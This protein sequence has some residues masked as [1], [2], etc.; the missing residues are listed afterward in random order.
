M[1]NL[2]FSLNIKKGQIMKLFFALGLIGV[3]VAF[4]INILNQTGVIEKINSMEKIRN[5]V[6]SGG[7]YSAIIFI[8]LQIL[9]TTILQIPAFILTVVGALVFGTWQSF[10]LSY[11]A[12][13]IGSIIMFWIGRKAGRR[14]LNWIVGENNA[15]TWIEKLSRGKYLFFL[16]MIFPLFPD[17][18]LCVVAGFTNM[19]FSF[20]LWTNIIAR[21][22]GIACTV[23][24]GSGSIIPFKGWG[25]IIWGFIIAFIV[26]LFYTSVKKR[27]KIDE[28]LS[29]I[30]K[31]KKVSKPKKGK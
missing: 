31:K 10:F 15:D 27:D 13:M 29:N 1:K 5:I 6:E 8:I 9:Q 3:L 12:I 16:M 19:S 14:F 2:K 11:I 18:I 7:A 20:F 30:F 26:L 22:I 25:L 21:G 28:I 17:D 24:F 23:F 4:G